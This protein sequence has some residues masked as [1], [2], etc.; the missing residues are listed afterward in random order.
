MLHR[1]TVYH[2]FNKDAFHIVLGIKQHHLSYS[3]IPSIIE[4]AATLRFLDHGSFQKSALNDYNT[5][6]G[7]STICTV[8]DVLTIMKRFI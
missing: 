1:F 4:L 6:L 2:R 7:R 3:K 5:S 8:M